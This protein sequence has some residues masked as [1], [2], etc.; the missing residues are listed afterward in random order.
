M[1]HFEAIWGALRMITVAIVRDGVPVYTRTAVEV[2]VRGGIVRYQL[3]TGARIKHCPSDGLLPLVKKMLATITEAPPR[4]AGG[5][6][7]EAAT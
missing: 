7:D 4:E 5:G 6:G 3:D 2:G 1:S